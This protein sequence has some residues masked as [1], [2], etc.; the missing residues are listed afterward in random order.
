MET[1]AHESQE[2][3]DASQGGLDMEDAPGTAG[4]RL[5]RDVTR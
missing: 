5:G 1:H 4:P 3:P 2:E